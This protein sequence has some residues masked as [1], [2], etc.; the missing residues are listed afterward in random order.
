M[1]SRCENGAGPSGGPVGA[2][3]WRAAAAG[4]PAHRSPADIDGEPRITGAYGW[5][6]RRGLVQWPSCSDPQFHPPTHAEQLRTRAVLDGLPCGRAAG[7][8]PHPPPPEP[9]GTTPPV[10]A[11]RR[12]GNSGR[13]PRPGSRRW[14]AASGALA[15]F[16]DRSRPSR[17][18]GACVP[19]GRARA[20][21]A[22]WKGNER[23]RNRAG[24]F[25]GQ[26]NLDSFHANPAEMTGFGMVN[27]AASREVEN[28]E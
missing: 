7:D 27:A 12:G 20:L 2:A 1:D 21:A 17:A 22:A 8:P 5:L 19:A 16:Q 23:R 15:P 11:D 18:S 10:D 3:G 14:S 9:G 26:S 25:S 6:I 4:R 28:V 24:N 13:S